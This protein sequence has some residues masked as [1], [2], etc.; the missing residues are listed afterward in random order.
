MLLGCARQP[1]ETTFRVYVYAQGSGAALQ[2]VPVLGAIVGGIWGLVSCCIGT[3]RAQEIPT[4]KATLAVL[5][6]M[7]V[8]CGLAIIGAVLIGVF[9]AMASR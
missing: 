9:G 1:F 4:G 5:L 6:P 8:C 7:F 3:A 2:V